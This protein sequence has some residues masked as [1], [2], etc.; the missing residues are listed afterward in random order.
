M[1]DRLIFIF[2]VIFSYSINHGVILLGS[3]GNSEL[4]LM[5]FKAQYN[6]TTL[7]SPIPPPP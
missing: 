2:F 1:Y 3:L 5:F 6:I 4:F 7:S